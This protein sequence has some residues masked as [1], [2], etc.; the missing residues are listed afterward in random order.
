IQY[1]Y[2]G[3]LDPIVN[4]IRKD[5]G[6]EESIV[7]NVSGRQM[8]FTF[9]KSEW[10]EEKLEILFVAMSNDKKHIVS[11]TCFNRKGKDYLNRTLP[12]RPLIEEYFNKIFNKNLSGS[13]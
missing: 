1:V 10:A 9:K 2:D 4:A 3:E 5:L 13:F 6:R 8:K 7:N 11:I 12:S